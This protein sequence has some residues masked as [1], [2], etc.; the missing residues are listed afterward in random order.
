LRGYAGVI[1]ENLAADTIIDAISVP[2]PGMFGTAHEQLFDVFDFVTSFPRPG[3]PVAIEAAFIAHS[4][5]DEAITALCRG[6]RIS[7]K[8]L[9]KHFG[10]PI[11]VGVV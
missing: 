7:A 3:C 6:Y 10:L 4:E 2:L 1:S 9:C 8:D 11:P 5:Y